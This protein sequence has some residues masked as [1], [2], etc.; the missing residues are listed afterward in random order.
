MLWPPQAWRMNNMPEKSEIIRAVRTAIEVEIVVAVVRALIRLLD[1]AY[2]GAISDRLWPRANHRAHTAPTARHLP[3]AEVSDDACMTKNVIET[4]MGKCRAFSGWQD[5]LDTPD[6][7]SV[8]VCEDGSVSCA[9]T[10]D[11]IE[12]AGFQSVEIENDWRKYWGF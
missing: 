11:R 8:V 2:D 1:G 4:T 12:S 10:G 5:E 6:D 7:A 3:V 9:V